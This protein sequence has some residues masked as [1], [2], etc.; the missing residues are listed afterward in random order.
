LL[1][2]PFCHSAILSSHKL[3]LFLSLCCCCC[4][5]WSRGGRNKLV[6]RQPLL[7][8]TCSALCNVTKATCWIPYG[9]VN[10][11]HWISCFF[12]SISS[13]FFVHHCL[14]FHPTQPNQCP[15]HAALCLDTCHV[16]DTKQRAIALQCIMWLEQLSQSN[17]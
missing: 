10:A 5:F 6:Q 7:R 1:L 9:Y 15:Y 2:L 12:P 11:N 16:R 8:R 14:L 4:C 3:I 13:Q 17:L